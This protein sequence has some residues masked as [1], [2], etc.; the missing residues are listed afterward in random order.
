MAHPIPIPAAT[1]SDMPEFPGVGAVPF[2]LPFT[3]PDPKPEEV[4][5]V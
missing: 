3:K 1:P 5:A 2:V 4:L